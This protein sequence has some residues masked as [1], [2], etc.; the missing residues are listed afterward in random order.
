M[1]TTYDQIL[2][3]LSQNK[4]NNVLYNNFINKKNMK[5]EITFLFRMIDDNQ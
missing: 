2:N 1:M 4:V 3:F 5:R